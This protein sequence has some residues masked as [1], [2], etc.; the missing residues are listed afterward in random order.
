MA[1]REEDEKVRAQRKRVN[2][3]SELGSLPYA[4][5][6]GEGEGRMKCIGLIECGK[7]AM[8]GS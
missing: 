4:Q 5:V 6:F 7:E 2:C 3:P 8:L 1:C